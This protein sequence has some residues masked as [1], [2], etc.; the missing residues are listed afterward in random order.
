MGAGMKAS[1]MRDRK[2]R[3]MAD[4]GALP[5]A[6]WTTNGADLPDA[7]W[8]APAATTS[9]PAG[10]PP[11]APDGLIDFAKTT[12][13]N[14]PSSAVKFGHDLIQPIIHPIETAENLKN[15]GLG[16]AE[17]VGLSSGTENIKYADAVGKFLA[18]R[19]GSVDAVKNT[20]ATDPVGFAADLSMFL[21]G[22]GS[23]AARIPGMAGKVGEV[24]NAVGRTVDPV[25]AAAKATRGVGSAAAE[26]IGGV[27][28]HTG[29]EAIR[30]AARA[31]AE[32]G[33]AARSFQENLR[34][35]ASPN[36]VVAEARNA[37]GEIRKQRG[38]AYREGM[39]G[40]SKDPA[41]LD[42][43]RVDD[44]LAQIS[45]VKTYKGQVISPKTQGIRQE[46]GETIRDWK[47]LDPAEFHTVEGMDALKQKLGDI[48][49]ATQ[50]GTPERVVADRAYHAVRKTIIDQAPEYARVM[51]GYE[52]ASKQIKEIEKTL[53][54]DPKANIDTALRKLQSVMRNNVNSNYGQR[55]KLAEFLV[56]SG[57]PNLMEKLAGQALSSWTPRGLGKLGMQ[58]G[59]EIAAL[60]AGHAAAG[61]A[62]VATA[63][64][65]LPLMSPRLVGEAAYYAGKASNAPIRP[66]SKAL[67]QV[68]RENELNPSLGRP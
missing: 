60:M 56:E 32:G 15:L 3:K 30:Q 49:D 57:A 16:V 43:D 29:G 5:D 45:G 46:I 42:F 25:N 14:I 20:L 33:E 4:G 7:P 44:A 66:A 51:K 13:S 9:A 65:T 54:L 23:A 38:E 31:G 10:E 63:A 2:K 68:G 37:V 36:D 21:T 55:G 8:A 62:G 11:T 61:P 17:K 27:G 28:T 67:F 41:I 47:A 50:Y 58:L 19:Y 24:V 22:G 12:A 34:G 18:D 53:S 26:V 35:T 6:P 1:V 59:T 48:R 40:I 52:E 64:A 39:S